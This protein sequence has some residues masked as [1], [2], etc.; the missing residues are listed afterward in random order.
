MKANKSPIGF[1]IFEVHVN[2]LKIITVKVINTITIDTRL[3]LI[4]YF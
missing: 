1:R 4:E 2:I 3:S